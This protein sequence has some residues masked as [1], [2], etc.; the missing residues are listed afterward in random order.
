MKRYAAPFGKAHTPMMV[1]ILTLLLFF[2]RD[3]MVSSAIVGFYPSQFLTLG[4]IGLMGVGFLAA[5][6]RRWKE[7]ITDS[8]M[9]LLAGA[10]F[11]CLLPLVVKR[12]WQLMYFSVLLCLLTGIFCT[13]FWEL[14]QGAKL[15]VCILSVLAVYSVLAAYLLRIG[16]D[17]GVYTVPVFYN[18]ANVKFFNF[19]LSVVPETYVKDRNFGIFREPGVYQFFLLL[20]LYLN[21]DRVSWDK[22]WKQWG[23]NAI[24]GVAMLSTFATGGV[25]EMG[26]LA[27]LLFFDKK[28][29]RQPRLRLAAGILVAAVAAVVAYCVVTKNSLYWS[30]YDMFYGKFLNDNESGSDRIQSIFGN[31][32]LFLENPLVGRDLWTVLHVALNNTSSTMI[33]F[34][35]FGILG[36]LAHLLA[37]GALVWKRE[38]KIWVNALYLVILLMSFNTQ[39]LIA[40]LFLWLFPMMALTEKSVPI[41]EGV[42]HRKAE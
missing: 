38:R 22:A 36:G 18:G 28:W 16:V 37:W 2:C 42:R 33:L 26:L 41:L 25:I 1:A 31:L 27:V 8:R 10:C 11:V 7:I 17:R 15:Y 13:Y 14:P 3:S 24:L 30:V 34:A 23:I 35:A 6:F 12:D 9:L 20:G 29:Y 5:N 19:F 40:D 4:L 21:N 39:N 32:A